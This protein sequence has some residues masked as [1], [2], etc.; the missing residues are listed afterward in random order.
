VYLSD[1]SL[2]QLKKELQQQGIRLRI[3]PFVVSLKSSIASVQSCLSLL[4]DS[5]PL[6]LDEGF[7][8][9]HIRLDTPP[10]Y[11]RFYK[12]QVRFYFDEREPF[13]PLPIAHAFPLFEWGLNWCIAKYVHQYLI[14]HSA[15]LEKNGKA[16]ILP[17]APGAGKSTLCAAMMLRG[18]RL[19]SDEMAL[20]S[21]S[22][23]RVRPIPRPV[24][25]KND[26]I[27]IIRAFDKSAVLGPKSYD[28]SKGTVA[29]L[30]PTHDCI[31]RADEDVNVR[32]VIM[33]KY[34]K[35]SHTKFM[36]L[37][38][39]EM[40][41]QLIRNSFNYNVMRESGFDAA[42]KLL[43]QSECFDLVYSDLGDVIKHLDELVMF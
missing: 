34:Q 11:R 42:C 39:P 10:S 29:H 26:S 15:V 6:A 40:L 35:D 38:K 25:L 30:R 17:G 1:L 31:T 12:P 20:I 16:I 3:G 13:K 43:D 28:T 21:P 23:Q 22:G 24:A 37:A 27:E 41:N 14:I 9:F 19:L 2:A 33:P 5:Y 36:Q 7:S 8:D 32:F 18:W 4:Y